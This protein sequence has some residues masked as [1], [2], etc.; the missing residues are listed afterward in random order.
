MSDTDQLTDSLA[1]RELRASLD[2]I[3]VPTRPPLETIT[4]RGR[5][6]RRR[7]RS[8]VMGL[9]GA[10]LATVAA[11]ILGLAG[12]FSSSSTPPTARTPSFKLVSYADGT[13]KLTLNPGELLNPTELQSD[14]AKFGIPAKVTDGSYCT[15]DPAPAGFAQ[16]VSGPG[17]GSWRQGSGRQPTITIDPSKIP[18]GTQLTVGHFNLPTGEQQAAVDRSMGQLPYGRRAPPNRYSRQPRRRSETPE[19]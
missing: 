13:A 9:T 1:L 2:D 16:A 14:F 4:A 7:R 17:P 8:T 15:S 3:A 6:R 11:A 10:G 19:K 18:A 12:G 5:E